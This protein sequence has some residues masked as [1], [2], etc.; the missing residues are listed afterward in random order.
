MYCLLQEDASAAG[1]AGPSNAGAGE[2]PDERRPKHREQT[3]SHVADM[4]AAMAAHQQLERYACHE[5]LKQQ[6]HVPWW[7]SRVT[8]N[9][10]VPTR[11]TLDALASFAAPCKLTSQVACC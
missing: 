11:S 8:Y 7:S 1:E 6:Q 2:R 5:H 10:A 9:E 3:K 4:L